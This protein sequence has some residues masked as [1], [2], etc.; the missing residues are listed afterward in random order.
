MGTKDLYER[1]LPVFPSERRQL[2]EELD[3]LVFKKDKEKQKQ[4]K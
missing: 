2:K 1:S 4:K 3:F